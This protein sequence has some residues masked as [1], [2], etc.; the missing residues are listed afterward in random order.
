[1]LIAV[2]QEGATACPIQE[3]TAVSLRI[4]MMTIKINRVAMLETLYKK[5]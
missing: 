4:Y 3:L 5:P 2:E 1:M